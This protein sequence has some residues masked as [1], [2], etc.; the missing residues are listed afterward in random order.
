MPLISRGALGGER[1]RGL[2]IVSCAGRRF[3]TTIKSTN[4]PTPARHASSVMITKRRGRNTSQVLGLSGHIH[5]HRR[6]WGGAVTSLDILSSS[7]RRQIDAYLLL[8]LCSLLCK[9]RGKRSFFFSRYRANDRSISRSMRAAFFCASPLVSVLVVFRAYST[10]HP[11]PRA[12]LR[13]LPPW[14]RVIPP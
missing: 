8:V 2:G 12:R 6:R 14:V 3:Q 1:E 7:T 4:Q 11:P 9:W 13:V 10:V 5:G